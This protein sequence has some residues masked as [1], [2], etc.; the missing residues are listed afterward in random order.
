MNTLLRVC[1]VAILVALFHAA[2]VGWSFGVAL[3]SLLTGTT[4]VLAC[5]GIAG[6]PRVKR[7]A[8]LTW[9]YWGLTYASNLIEA[10]YFR[11]IPI[12]RCKTVCYWRAGYRTARGVHLGVVGTG[13]EPR[14]APSCL[15]RPTPVVARSF[16]GVIVL[17]DL[18]ECRNCD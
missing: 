3:S 17:R 12:L 16:S 10:L 18:P 15:D 4:L 7:I 5:D 1:A 2:T 9:L 11:V 13:E 8:I 6:T 14:T